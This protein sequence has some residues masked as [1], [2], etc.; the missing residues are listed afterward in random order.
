M[1]ASHRGKFRDR[2]LK[3]FLIRRNKNKETKKDNDNETKIKRE[4]KKYVYNDFFENVSKL[5][6]T[7]KIYRVK[8]Q[9]K[10][11]GKDKKKQKKLDSLE[12]KYKLAFPYEKTEK[13]AEENNYSYQNGKKGKTF[14]NI[15]DFENLIVVKVESELQRQLDILDVIKSDAYILSKEAEDVKTKEECV[16][17][18]KRIDDLMKKLSKIK[19]EYNVL[20][21]KSLDIDYVELGNMSL[22]DLISDYKYLMEDDSFLNK[23]KKSY[24]KLNLFTEVSEFIEK[25]NSEIESVDN[26]T[27][28]L[29]SKLSLSEEKMYDIKQSTYNMDEKI[30]KYVFYINSQLKI[31]N[32]LDDKVGKIDVNER[33]KTIKIGYEGLLS[34]NLKYLTL[35]MLSPLKGIFPS[36]ALSTI[37]TK[38]TLDMIYKRAHTEKVKE[39]YYNAR[40]YGEFIKGRLYSI[41]DMKNLVEISLAEIKQIKNDFKKE[42]INNESLEYIQLFNKIESIEKMLITNANKM[43]FMEKRLMKQKKLNDSSLSKVKKLNNNS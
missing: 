30:D 4:T 21:S 11:I 9:S 24:K 29:C 6:E 41:N 38:Q 23:L 39:V 32:D 35:L 2:I 22:V 3:I 31:I 37:A 13:F 19:E 26:D 5:K 12:K 28:K 10:A 34:N 36:I 42:V 16:E 1:S 33:I 27:R 20:K 18:Q 25:V 14:K 7:E 17:L 8:V 43:N 40:D 15:D